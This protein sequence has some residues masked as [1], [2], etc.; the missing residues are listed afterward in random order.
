MKRRY[1]IYDKV[2]RLNDSQKASSKDRN[3]M[4]IIEGGQTEFT[5]GEV[6]FHEFIALLN[7]A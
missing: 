4:S 1:E 2:Y 7:L 5:Y 3:Q 6:L